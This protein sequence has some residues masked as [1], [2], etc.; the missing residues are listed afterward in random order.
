MFQ[1]NV[2]PLV[3]KTDPMPE[4]E[5][6]NQQPVTAPERQRQAWQQCMALAESLKIKMQ[7]AAK[8]HA[9]E[10]ADG[11]KR[12]KQQDTRDFCIKAGTSAAAAAVA[13]IEVNNVSNNCSSISSIHSWRSI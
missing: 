3:A 5:I 9:E 1:L 12:M 6:E 11:E 13:A 8:R 10:W 7:E 4:F 2:L